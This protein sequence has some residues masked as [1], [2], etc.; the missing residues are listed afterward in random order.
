MA[1]LKSAALGKRLTMHNMRDIFASTMLGKGMN[2]ITVS[3]MLGHRDAATTL[4]HYTWAVPKS[5]RTVAEAM[6][7]VI[8][9]AI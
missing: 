3:D 6:D 8:S 7:S 1:V 4:R 9:V 2:V 5:G